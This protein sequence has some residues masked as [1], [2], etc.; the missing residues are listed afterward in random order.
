MRETSQANIPPP[1]APNPFEQHIQEVESRRQSRR[2]S[3]QSKR[4]SKS[5]PQVE[6]RKLSV[7]IKAEA[8]TEVEVR[9]S[10]QVLSQAVSQENFQP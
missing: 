10:P 2:E 1:A 7:K 5:P 6:E 8:S 9:S 4:L 3:K